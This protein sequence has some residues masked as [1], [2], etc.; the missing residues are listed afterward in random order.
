MPA[1]IQVTLDRTSG[2]VFNKFKFSKNRATSPVLRQD[3]RPLEESAMNYEQEGDVAVLHFDDGKANVV[4]HDLIAAMHQGLDRAQEEAQAVVILG[5]PGRFSA[6]FDLEEFKKG[7]QAGVELVTAGARMLLR[8]FSHPQPLI[9]ACTGH[10]VAAGAFMLLSCDTR[11]GIPGDFK[12]GLNETSIG[13][14]LPV[15][16]L[17]LAAAR[18]SRRHLTAATIQ[19]RLYNPEDA[20]DAGFLDM[21]VAEEDLKQRSIET[22][23]QL[24]V[25]PAEAYAGNKLAIRESSIARI[26]HSLE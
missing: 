5:R 12:L 16:G 8:M 19:A 14:V 10:A 17:E 9:G 26:R 4:G 24:A 11:I 6:G 3:M 15:F 18:L 25:Y 21:I 13:M 2:E 1:F 7:Q 23:A 20:V 22:A